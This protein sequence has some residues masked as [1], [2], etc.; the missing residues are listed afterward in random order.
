MSKLIAPPI[1]GRHR[2]EA[3]GLVMDVCNST[4]YLVISPKGE[5]IGL[6]TKPINFSRKGLMAQHTEVFG[7][8]VATNQE[9]ED[10]LVWVGIG[11]PPPEKEIHSFILVDALVYGNERLVPHNAQYYAISPTGVINTFT[12][13]PTLSMAGWVAQG[14]ITPIGTADPTD[15]VDSLRPIESAYDDI[16]F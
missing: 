11:N 16:P 15:W 1:Q 5:I 13:R 10:T 7:K 12:A 2:I 6:K 8:V 4:K 9:P 14:L 3:Y